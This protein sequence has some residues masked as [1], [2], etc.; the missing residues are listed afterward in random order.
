MKS[1]V[2]PTAMSQN[3]DL[4][5][6]ANYPQQGIHFLRDD[7]SS[8]SLC[9]LI[10][11]CHSEVNSADFH[12]MHMIALLQEKDFSGGKSS[13][14]TMDPL[15][16]YKVV[17]IQKNRGGQIYTLPN[18]HSSLHFSVTDEVAQEIIFCLQFL[19][20][21]DNP[22]DS[23]FIKSNVNFHQD[24]CFLFNHHVEFLDGCKASSDWFPNPDTVLT[25]SSITLR[26]HARRSPSKSF[27][28][29]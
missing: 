15:A 14:A 5:V 7:Y 1:T 17:S 10:A 18:L 26:N 25:K 29:S 19:W 20:G 28:G 22:L 24:K 16:L 8:S 11:L 21:S 6:A 4:Y 13:T 23:K 12:R 3:F 27:Y 9:S 2:S